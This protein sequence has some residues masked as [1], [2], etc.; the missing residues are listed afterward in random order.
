MEIGINVTLSSRQI[1]LICVTFLINGKMTGAFV[2]R[3]SS[4]PFLC[5]RIGYKAVDSYYNTFKVHLL[6]Q[7][8]SRIFNVNSYILLRKI[9]QASICLSEHI[10]KYW[11]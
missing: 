1:M 8:L 3:V 6:N 4:K 11:K 9:G 10:V 2:E 5:F 7:F